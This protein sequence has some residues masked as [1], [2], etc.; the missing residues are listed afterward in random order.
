MSLSRRTLL[1]WLAGAAISSSTS[2]A[3]AAPGRPSPRLNN[4]RNA[5]TEAIGD[6]AIGLD[7]RQINPETGDEY[8]RIQINADQLYPVASCFKTW[9]AL[10]YLWYTPEA[11]WRYGEGAPV[12]ST[13]V[14]SNNTRTGE[15]IDQVG[16]RINRYGNALE[17]F[18]D[19][20]LFD[21]G[22]RH[23]LY[24][25]GW[26]GTPVEDLVDR[27]FTPSLINRHITIGDERYLMD[28][29]STAADLADGYAFL[30]HPPDAVYQQAA[31]ITLGLCSISAPEF[32]APIERAFER[33]YT[34]K[35]GVLPA[36]RSVIGRVINDA[37]V[38]TVGQSTYIIG[39][40]CAGEGEWVGMN[41]LREIARI[42][43]DYEAGL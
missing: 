1:K 4:L 37:G 11:D 2:I 32:P 29:L 38:I 42:L 21:M 36:D 40:L 23:G 16:A 14:Y 12:H 22:L 33:D 9:L 35:D 6:L 26:E 25:W 31:N 41:V 3:W 19:F 13:I 24:R 10:Y 27:R 20:L 43:E 28:N 39:Y 17:K 7:L 34:G 15:L 8:L 30:L 18:N 5:L